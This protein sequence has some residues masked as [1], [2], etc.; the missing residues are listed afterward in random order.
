VTSRVLVEVSPTVDA[1][2]WARLNTAGIVPDR[3]PYGLHRLADDGFSVLVRTPPRSRAIVLLSRVGAKV[4]GG[5]R[6]PESVLGRPRWS[7]ADVRLCWDER[8]GI[9]AVL[10]QI[11]RHGRRPV[12]TGVIWIA[13][14][15]AALSALARR[16]GRHAL[17]RADAVFVLSSAQVPALRVNWGV[18]AARIHLV[19]FGID[20]DFWDPSLATAVSLPEVNS[21]Q[22]S[23]TASGGQERPAIVSVGNDRHRDHGLLLAAVREA[24]GKLPKA[25]LE[26]VTSSSCQ[27]PAE[28]GRWRRS[29]THPEL[30]DLYRR[31]RVVAMCTRPNNH[32]SGITAILE[33]MAMGKP[34]VAT[35]TPG[36]EDYITHGETGVLVPNG[37]ADAMAR[38]LVELLED[39]D[40]CREL[41]TEAR[42]RALS[43]FSTQALAQ[44]L[45]S[46]IRSVL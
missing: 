31:A 44:R 35:H 41:G 23:S 7:D 17:E 25:R 19:H 26:L 29:V 14:P 42:K 28:M 39:S 36:L 1:V 6:W 8:V 10:S 46:V 5:A 27:I 20:T 21:P 33:A 38:A 37:D 13:E 11:R 45:A 32:A 4:T 34:V 9:P 12:V 43:Y 30:R 3:V 24:H 15:D 40:R 2:R 22:A 16:I 18:D